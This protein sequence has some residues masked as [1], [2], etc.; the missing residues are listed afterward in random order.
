[1]KNKNLR[2]GIAL[3]L[4]STLTLTAVPV[5]AE[6]VS[7]HNAV[8]TE[9]NAVAVEDIDMMLPSESEPEKQAWEDIEADQS[10]DDFDADQ[11]T[12]D[13]EADQTTGTTSDGLEYVINEREDESESEIT[14]T[15]YTG[16]ATE[17]DIPVSIN[18]IPVTYIGFSAFRNCSGLKSITIPN[19]VTTIDFDAFCRCS[20][21]TSI[22][23]PN[24]VTSI[25]AAAFRDCSSLT[26][27]TIPES[28]ETIGDYA[29]CDCI[30]LTSIT[31]SNCSVMGDGV[32]S[33][34][35][36]LKSI[37]IPNGVTWIKSNT[38][39]GCSS[40]T[41]ITIPQSV[42]SIRD[43]AFQKCSSLKDVYYTGYKIQWGAIDISKGND[44][45]L[46]A[47]IHFN[48]GL[49]EQPDDSE[50]AR[51][52]ASNAVELIKAI[53]T[54]TL[55]RRDAIEQ[56]R[57]ACDALTDE[58]K[59]YVS[60]A[61][62]KLLTD[63]ETKYATLKAEKAAA[64]KAAADKA[65]AEKKA[66]EEKAAKEKVGAQNVVGNATYVVTGKQTVAFKGY[67]KKDATTVKIPTTIKINDKN[68]TVTEIAANAFKNNKKLKKVTISGNIKVIGKNAFQNCTALKTV[69][70]GSKV[71]TISDG[72]FQGCSKL[73]KITIPAK[74]TKI[75]K[76]AFYNCKN[77]KSV[78]IKTN[79]LKSV[80]KSAFKKI[81][82][83][84]TIKVPKKK[85][86]AYKKLLKGKT[87]SDV[88]I[89]K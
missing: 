79:A 25:E 17:V 19:S 54:V 74:V 44:P 31:I 26:S 66:A 42:I 34:C 80:G 48:S 30:C 18:S 35:S 43:W 20:S 12:E 87:T 10:T 60:D 73:T 22:T 16:T 75:G 45:L 77:L 65:A 53:G 15:G 11:S 14:I 33:G 40:L 58:A 21:L 59:E 62:F 51:Q 69:A 85:Y 63:A 27:I 46:N 55:E 4:V 68:F 9:E 57:A 83:K 28:V 56:A 37:T 47:T 38:F 84:A 24:S 82:K 1:M 86:T 7:D 52:A 36:G 23:I 2:K 61:D 88:K 64:D 5:S 39:Y 49:P 67:E 3:L 76:N 81:A 89:K 8:S 41:S 50:Q 71:T 72:A 13:I 29:F 70:I 78:T 6:P 32:F